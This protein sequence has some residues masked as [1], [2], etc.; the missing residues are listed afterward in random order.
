MGQVRKKRGKTIPGKEARIR[1]QDAAIS[2]EEQSG[3]AACG[4]CSPHASRGSRSAF[5]RLLEA[6]TCPSVSTTGATY[7]CAPKV[8]CQ[9]SF[10]VGGEKGGKREKPGCPITAPPLGSS[11]PSTPTPCPFSH[12]FPVEPCWE[13][14]P[15]ESLWF[16]GGQAQAERDLSLPE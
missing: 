2:S 9:Y 12:P 3:R 8:N 4:L 7:V 13:G 15:R 11:K 6:H 1:S 10:R 14:S 16:Q 5:L